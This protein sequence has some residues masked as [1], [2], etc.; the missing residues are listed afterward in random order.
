MLEFPIEDLGEADLPEAREVVRIAFATFMGV[1]APGEFWADRD[2][3]EGRWRAPH[4]AWFKIVQ[5]GRIA[6][7]A[8]VARWGSHAVVGPVAVLPAYWDRK[9]AKALMGRIVAQLDAWGVRHAGLFTFPDSPR[10]IG[11]YQRFGFWPR[12]LTA[13]LDREVVPGSA[14]LDEPHGLP[15]L[16]EQALADCAVLT[17]GLAEGLDVRG[18]LQAVEVLGLGSNLLLY[19]EGGQLDSFAACHF[20]PRS[21]AGAEV[22]YVKFGAVRG[23]EGVE[24]RFDRLIE[25]CEGVAR[26]TGQRRLMLGVN[27]ARQPAYARLLNRGFAIRI[28]GIT[29]HRGSGS[30]D[31]PECW[32]LDD[33][34]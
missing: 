11:L 4:T 15:A 3:V 30:Y 33:W 1:P 2:Y 17:G 20:G 22:C 19:G 8:G 14:P 16:S 5:Q 13:V 7:V 29:L 24:V 25:A 32:V 21:E 18:E 31:R 26:T 6:A 34:R 10:H 12:A 28:L 23:G 9:L 27:T